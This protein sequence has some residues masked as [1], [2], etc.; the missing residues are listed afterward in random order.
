[1]GHDI[2]LRPMGAGVV[3]QSSAVADSVP[4]SLVTLALPK[5]RLTDSC[6]VLTFGL[7]VKNLA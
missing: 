2:A 7:G 5:I 6:S 3:G 4:G 1:M